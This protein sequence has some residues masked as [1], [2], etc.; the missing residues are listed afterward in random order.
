[1]LQ[2]TDSMAQTAR[3]CSFLDRPWTLEDVIIIPSDSDSDSGTDSDD[4]V[5]GHGVPHVDSVRD[6]HPDDSLPSISAIVTS[7]VNVRRVPTEDIG[8][9]SQSSFKAGNWL[10]RAQRVQ[11]RSFALQRIE[12]FLIHQPQT[13]LER[14]FSLQA[15]WRAWGLPATLICWFLHQYNK[16]M[17]P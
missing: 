4:E 3:T 15:S 12:R 5:M 11:H 8:E 14:C 9:H 7:V 13:R 1:M 6:Q 2:Y 10:T 16:T 17:M